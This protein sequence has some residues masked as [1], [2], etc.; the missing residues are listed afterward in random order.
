MTSVW[1]TASLKARVEVRKRV[2]ADEELF[3]SGCDGRYLSLQDV[4]EVATWKFVGLNY[5]DKSHTAAHS[6]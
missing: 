6:I 2:P 3:S 4:G 1:I 5:G